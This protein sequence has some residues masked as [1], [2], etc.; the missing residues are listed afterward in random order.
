MVA[1]FPSLGVM[2]GV[3]AEY[4]SWGEGEPQA[5]WTHSDYAPAAAAGWMMGAGIV[6]GTTAAVYLFVYGFIEPRRR[7]RLLVLTLTITAG[8]ALMIV[9]LG[10]GRNFVVFGLGLALLGIGISGLWV[11]RS[12]GTVPVARSAWADTGYSITRPRT[13]LTPTMLGPSA[14]GAGGATTGGGASPAEPQEGPGAARPAMTRRSRREATAGGAAA[15]GFATSPPESPERPVVP[16]G[17]AYL[18]NLL[19]VPG[20]TAAVWLLALERPWWA[21]AAAATALVLPRWASRRLRR[22]AVE[23]LAAM[24]ASAAG[25]AGLNTLSA[26]LA[27][28]PTA[29]GRLAGLVSTSV[30]LGALFVAPIMI[31]EAVLDR[32]A[33]K[34]RLGVADERLAAWADILERGMGPTAAAA[35]LLVVVWTAFCV[36]LFGRKPDATSA[37]RAWLSLGVYLLVFVV[38]FVAGGGYPVGDSPIAG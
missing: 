2:L 30:T 19:S 28:E 37:T 8:F 27:F 1:G 24:S 17:I 11:L 22:R 34:L 35:C 4:A 15:T 5:A 14:A 7:R 10:I 3:L 31:E 36:P 38:Y 29:Y 16:G 32:R 9:G 13:W 12:R 25:A 33:Q 26:R 20:I 6:L 23:R 21:L 18:V